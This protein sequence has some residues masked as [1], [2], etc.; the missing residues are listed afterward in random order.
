M[1][2]TSRYLSLNY[3]Y[4]EF[5][6]LM[7]YR[8]DRET[9]KYFEILDGMMLKDGYFFKRAALDSL[10]LWGVVPSEEELLKFQPS[11]N[12]ESGDLEWL[13]HLYGEQ[14]KKR[15]MQFDKGGEKGEGSSKK[16]YN[17]YD[18][19]GTGLVLYFLFIFLCFN[20]CVINKFWIS[21][22]VACL[23]IEDPK[24]LVSLLV[25]RKRIATWYG[26]DALHKKSF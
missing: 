14:M 9:G 20:V 23:A 19:V 2:W 24:V 11:D 12:G 5:R 4:R 26:I 22:P 16:E 13:S 17:M 25:S 1:E 21:F 3:L 8:R 15:S 6:P 18:L 10:T 7:Q